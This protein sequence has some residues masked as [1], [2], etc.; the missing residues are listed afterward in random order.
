[1]STKP[2]MRWVGMEDSGWRFFLIYALIAI[3][4]VVVIGFAK[5]TMKRY[6]T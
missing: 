4:F 5:R 2:M 1:M 6:H 3:A